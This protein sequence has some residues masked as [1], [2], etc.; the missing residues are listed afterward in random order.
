M[1]G[2]VV[3]ILVEAGAEIKTGDGVIIVEAMKMQ[4]ELKAR[5]DGVVKEIRFSEGSTVNAGDV[6]V[7]IE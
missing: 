6:L 3:R 7:I 5:K 1:P 4:N 2:K